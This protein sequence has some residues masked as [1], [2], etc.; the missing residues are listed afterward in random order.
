MK[1]PA[2]RTR[3]IS[4]EDALEQFELALLAQAYLSNE[5]VYLGRGDF[6]KWDQDGIPEWLVPKLNDLGFL[7]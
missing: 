7:P 1:Q 4:R 3:R 5:P 6:W 2:D